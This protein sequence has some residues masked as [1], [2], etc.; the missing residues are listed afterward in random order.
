MSLIKVFGFYFEQGSRDFPAN[1]GVETP[2]GFE[3]NSSTPVFKYS[4]SDVEKAL[5][6]PRRLTSP[7]LTGTVTRLDTLIAE[8]NGNPDLQ[9]QDVTTPG[10]KEVFKILEYIYQNQTICRQS[11]SILYNNNTGIGWT[12]KGDEDLNGITTSYVPH[13][14]NPVPSNKATRLASASF[15]AS[16]GSGVVEFTIYFDADNFVERAD[17]AGFAVY[18]YE[19]LTG[20]DKISETEFNQQIVQKLFD[21]NKTGRYRQYA[22]VDIDKWVAQVVNGVPTGITV[23][24]VEVFYVFTTY[25]KD[26]VN[27][28]FS[29]EVKL[30]QIKN[31]L[32]G[33]YTDDYLRATYRTLFGDDV[34]EVIPIYE[35]VVS[36]LGGTTQVVHPISLGLLRETMNAFGKNFNPDPS[37]ANYSTY[38]P[39]EVF[40]V[41]SDVSVPNKY[42]YPI[43]AVESKQNSYDRPIA[44]RFPNYRPLY[45]VE[46]HPTDG[47]AESFHH[48]MILALSVCTGIMEISSIDQSIVDA[49]H[50]EYHTPNADNYN[51]GYVSFSF[52]GVTWKVFAPSRAV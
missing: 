30:L 42:A 4:I 23:Q 50:M 28:P 33:K 2:F 35:N 31:Y 10:W 22:K 19:D 9:T 11:A 25:A 34:V 18:R 39:S 21:I 49:I 32:R 26:Q 24:E 27:S 52:S 38:L 48:F 36:V 16:T 43:I 8:A 17:G 46:Y 47:T 37:A 51:R 12:N 45:G 1:F 41:G 29:Q 15:R 5:V 6:Q 7:S 14:F 40:Y 44:D 13:S 3:V 20:D